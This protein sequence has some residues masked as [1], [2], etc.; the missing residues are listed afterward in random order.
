MEGLSSKMLFLIRHSVL[1][2]IVSLPIFSRLL[3]SDQD[4]ILFDLSFFVALTARIW[5]LCQRANRDYFFAL[6]I[7]R[8]LKLWL[9]TTRRNINFLLQ[10]YFCLFKF[11]KKRLNSKK[12]FLLLEFRYG[13]P[14]RCCFP[15]IYFQWQS[16]LWLTN[17]V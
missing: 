3:L 14:V 1:N 13:T 17:D 5:V 4:T 10:I 15:L 2:F 7:Q 11:Q 8:R 16:D 12:R 9:I 6:I